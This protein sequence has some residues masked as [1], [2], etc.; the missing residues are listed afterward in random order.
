M[1]PGD[2]F[3]GR[4]RTGAH[5]QQMLLVGVDRMEGAGPLALGRGRKGGI[6]QGHH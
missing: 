2:S 3:V 5:R 6:C 1:P 4:G